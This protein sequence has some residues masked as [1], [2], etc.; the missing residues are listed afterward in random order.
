[1][2]AAIDDATRLGYTEQ[3]GD[4]RGETAAAFLV[5]ASSFFAEQGIRTER[6]LTDNGSPFRSKA[7]ANACTDL[8]V[9]QRYTRPYRPQTN[10]KVERFFRTLLDECLYAQSFTS[11]RARADALD[12]FVCYYNAERP[13]LGLRGLT[14]RQRLALPPSL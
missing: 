13:H 1:V 9:R 5:R 10:G 3:L 6:V 11:D 2:Y 8:A 14:P 12:A 4:E 7:W